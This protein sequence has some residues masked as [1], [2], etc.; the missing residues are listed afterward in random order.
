MYCRAFTSS[1]KHWQQITPFLSHPHPRTLPHPHPIHTPSNPIGMLRAFEAT[2]AEN[3]DRQRRRVERR[4]QA[5]EQCN[6]DISAKKSTLMQ[7]LQRRDAVVEAAVNTVQVL[8]P[9]VLCHHTWIYHPPLSPLT[10]CRVL[11]LCVVCVVSR[12]LSVSLILT[13]ILALTLALI[14]SLALQALETRRLSQ[15]KQSLA[16][17]VALEKA[18]CERR[19]Q[20]LGSVTTLPAIHH[21]SPY[22]CSFILPPLSPYMP[23]CGYPLVVIHS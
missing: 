6:E 18:V 21:I 22:H 5:V 12:L 19:M 1:T 10:V 8:T 3:R 4:Y 20:Q 13:L 15:T 11:C 7:T 14:L 16:D 17:Y 2:P 23:K 9:L